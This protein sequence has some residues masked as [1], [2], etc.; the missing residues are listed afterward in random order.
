MGTRADF[1]I[2]RGKQAEWLG[3]IA[4]DGYPEGIDNPVKNATTAAEFREAVITLL[5]GRD[6]AT[7]PDMGWPWP[8]EDSRTTDFAYAFDEGKVYAAHFGHGWF[9]PFQPHIPDSRECDFPD[10]K[11]KKKVTLG[12]RSGL[13]VLKTP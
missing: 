13:I 4:W 1:Y 2:G 7:V 5:A 11:D 8:W 10:M 6:D 12:P 3:S 9:N